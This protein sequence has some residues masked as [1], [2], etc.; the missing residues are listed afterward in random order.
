MLTFKVYI[1]KNPSRSQ[2]LFT[3]ICINIYYLQIAIT[4]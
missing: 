2:G 1:K 3:M 4:S